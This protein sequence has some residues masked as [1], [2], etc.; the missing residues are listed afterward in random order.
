MDRLVIGL[1]CVGLLSVS[2]GGLFKSARMSIHDHEI[3]MLINRVEML[4]AAINRR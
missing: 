2:I 1:L 4:E 3:K